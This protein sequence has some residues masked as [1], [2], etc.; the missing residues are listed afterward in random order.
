MKF[1]ELLNKTHLNKYI[2]VDTDFEVKGISFDSRN[3]SS[4]YVFF[5]VKGYKQDGN[6]YIRDAAK[7]GAKFIFCDKDSQVIPDS[8]LDIPVLKIPDIRKT[9]ALI[10]TVFYGNPSRK[11]NLIGI[12]GTNGKTTISY[13]IKHILESTGS[14]CGLIGTINYSVGS[15]NL[16]ANLTTP[17]AI[18]I[19]KMLAEMVNRNTDYCVMEVSSIALELYRVYGLDFNSGIFTNLTSEHLDLHK[20]MMNYFNAK[21][22]LFDGLGDNTIAVSNMDDEYGTEILQNTSAR[23]IYYS[24]NKNSDYRAINESVSMEGMEFDIKTKRDIVKIKTKL[25][26]RFN[27]YN[28]TA[29]YAF[30]ESIGVEKSIITES[31]SKF[32]PVTGRFNTLKLPNEA[33]AVIDYSHTSD[34]LKNAIE[35]AIEIRKH[36]NSSGRIITVFG[37]G[38]NKDRTKRPVMGKIASELSDFTI[39]TSDNPR[40]EEPMDIINEILKGVDKNSSFEVCENREEAIKSGIKMSKKSDIILICGKGHETYQE[41]KGIKSYFDDKEIVLKYS[42]L[43]V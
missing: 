21:K 42:S 6:V 31:I 24:V 11:I 29:A 12:T 37:C 39:I 18:E 7:K 40:F 34:S 2:N 35:S 3:V 30:A 38:G 13:L 41:V 22:I 25:T 17:D 28:I 1:S 36:S 14:K 32:E 43:A 19:N 23:K 5:A 9:L 16:I 15:Q 8:D 26:G 33:Y 27:I 4:D 20:N 10:G